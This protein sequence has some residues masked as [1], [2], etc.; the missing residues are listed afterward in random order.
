V[1]DK[2]KYPRGL[3]RYATENAM[4]GRYADRDILRHVLRFR[5]LAYATLLAVIVGALFAALVMRSPLK[6]N[7]VR[8][9]GT[10]SR[11]LPDGR[12]ANVYQLQIMNTDE[13]ARRLRV[14]ASGMDGLEVV[15]RQPVD[16]LP[17]SSQLVPAELRVNAD[18]LKPGSYA[19]VF[20]VES[21]QDAH[22]RRDEKSV[23]IVR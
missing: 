20:H 6:V 11:D 3:I 8:D 9:R 10:L 4:R 21:E 2:M 12:I 5:T 23:F 17:A 13:T 14:T 22:I 15:V 18:G 1:M 16:V 19:V 7:V